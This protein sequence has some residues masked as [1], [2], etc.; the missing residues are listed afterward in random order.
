MVFVNDVVN[1]QVFDVVQIYFIL[2]IRGLGV[3]DGMKFV[4]GF[5]VVFVVVKDV[6]QDVF[7]DIFC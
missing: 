2:V 4:F 5:L 1:S 7:G 6:W 3:V